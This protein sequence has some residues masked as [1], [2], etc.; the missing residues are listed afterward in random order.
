MIAVSVITGWRCYDKAKVEMTEDLNQ[1][2]Q[3]TAITDAK[4]EGMLDSLSSMQG[5]PMLTF[6]GNHQGFANFLRIP[7]LRDTAHV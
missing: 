4:V 5:S 3:R 7:S 1:A 2:L 6:N